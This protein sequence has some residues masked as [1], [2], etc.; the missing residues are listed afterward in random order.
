[1]QFE[2][3][4]AREALDTELAVGPSSPVTQRVVAFLRT[5]LAQNCLGAITWFE[6]CIDRHP[7]CSLF[8]AGAIDQDERIRSKARASTSHYLHLSLTAKWTPHHCILAI[9]DSKWTLPYEAF[10]E[11]HAKLCDM[12]SLLVYCEASAG[13]YLPDDAM[14]TLQ[15]AVRLICEYHVLDPGSFFQVVKALE[16]LGIGQLLSQVEEWSEPNDEFLRET[17]AGFL[18]H[19]HGYRFAQRWIALLRSQPVEFQTELSCLSKISGHPFVD[20]SGGVRKVQSR[21]RAPAEFAPGT[22][23]RLADLAK[24]QFCRAYYAKRR[25][26]PKISSLEGVPNHLKQMIEGNKR[27]D[28]AAIARIHGCALVA[29]DYR[30]LVLA[31]E[32]VVACYEN[33][34][35][36]LKDRTISPRL[37]EMVRVHIIPLLAKALAVPHGPR[38]SPA[39]K[40]RST[41]LLCH[42]I[43]S[44]MGQLGYDEFL[45]AYRRED[46]FELPLVK[47]ALLLKLVSKELELKSDDP[48]QFA[49]QTVPDRH[50]RQVTEAA[51]GTF[52]KE[53]SNE[54][55]MTS[56]EIKLQQQLSALRRWGKSHPDSTTLIVSLDVR[57]WNNGFR[58][59]LVDTVMSNTLA[60]YFGDPL[61]EAVH[62]AYE[63]TH[64][65]SIEGSSFVDYWFGQ[66]GGI[67]GLNQYTWVWV[68]LVM[69]HSIF[70]RWEYK[71][72]F[73]CHGDDFRAYISIPNSVVAARGMLA[74][75]QEIIAVVKRGLADFNLEVKTYDSYGSSTFSSFK[76]I[77]SVDSIV[78]PTAFRKMMKCHSSMDMVLPLLDAYIGTCFSTAHGGCFTAPTMVPAYAT[79]LMWACKH[80]LSHGLYA[81][82]PLSVLAA[83]LIVPANLGGFPTLCPENLA[84]RASADQTTDFINRYEF[85]RRCAPDLA[86]VFERFL[87]QPMGVVAAEG[88]SKAPVL[89][90]LDD[91]YAFP[92]SR[93]TLPLTLLRS[94]LV[95]HIR[96]IT[97]NELLR[98]IL[99]AAD[100][101]SDPAVADAL[102][103]SPVWSATLAAEIH[104]QSPQALL[105]DFLTKF[106]SG[107][108]VLQ[109]LL[110]AGTRKKVIAKTFR[111]CMRQE[112]KLHRWR[113]EVATGMKGLC[114]P[115]RRAVE[116]L[117]LDFRPRH[118]PHRRCP[119]RIRDTL[120]STA[121]GRKIETAVTA[122]P[123]HLV[124]IRTA[125]DVVASGPTAGHFLVDVQSTESHHA[126]RSQMY[127]RGPGEPYVAGATSSSTQPGSLIYPSEDPVARRLVNLV[128][129]KS[130]A[131]TPLPALDGNGDRTDSLSSLALYYLHALAPSSTVETLCQAGPSRLRGCR[132]HHIHTR[133]GRS[134]IAM[135]LSSSWFSKISVN[136]DANA[137][138]A[139]SAA[140]HNINYLHVVC[141]IRTTLLTRLL[142][143]YGSGPEDGTY[144]ASTD[145]CDH[146]HQPY[147]EHP[148]EFP[149]DRLLAR[150]SCMVQNLAV[151]HRELLRLEDAIKSYHLEHERVADDVDAQ[152]P[153][154]QQ[155]ACAIKCH[156]FTA[157]QN[158]HYAE[159]RD[160]FASTTG[161]LTHREVG[162]LA[163]LSLSGAPNLS[164]R[165]LR[166]IPISAFA[167]ELVVLAGTLYA[168]DGAPGLS[169]KDWFSYEA[170]AISPSLLPWYPVISYIHESG[171]VSD[172]VAQ[173][174][175][176]C[177]QPVPPTG[178]RTPVDTVR[179]VTLLGPALVEHP[180]RKATVLNVD[181]NVSEHGFMVR[182][183][184]WL[185]GRWAHHHARMW[186]VAFEEYDESCPAVRDYLVWKT[187][188]RHLHLPESLVAPALRDLRG[189]CR[190][191]T[192]R[193]FPLEQH[194]GPDP[195]LSDPESVGLLGTK[196]AL[197][198]LVQD[199]ESWCGDSD[200]ETLL[201]YVLTQIPRLGLQALDTVQCESLSGAEVTAV[202]EEMPIAYALDTE[203]PSREVTSSD[204]VR[205]SEAQLPECWRSLQPHKRLRYADL[206]AAEVRT[207][208]ITRSL[209]L[210]P[211][212]SL[213]H[214]SLLEAE[215]S[216]VF[217]G[218]G[219]APSS[220]PLSAVVIEDTGGAIT[221]WLLQR[222]P[223]M[224]VIVVLWR[225]SASLELPLTLRTRSD[226]AERV[227]T[228]LQA[229]GL[230]RIG[231]PGY[232]E[233]F[234]QTH[235]GPHAL[236]V[237]AQ[238]PG[239]NGED[240]HN[241][242]TSVLGLASQT[243]T[244]NCA[245]WVRFPDS[246]PSSLLGVVT[247]TSTVFRK[248]A[249]V[250]PECCPG[251]GHYG[252]VGHG[253][254]T[255]AIDQP[256]ILPTIAMRHLEEIDAA[257]VAR[258][259]L[260]RDH[261]H[262]A[263]ALPLTLPAESHGVC[264]PPEQALCSF[265]ANL[266]DAFGVTIAATN[267]HDAVQ[268][269]RA[270]IRGVRSGLS[271]SAHTLREAHRRTC[272]W[273]GLRLCMDLA[274]ELLP[275]DGLT[276]LPS[277]SV[278]RQCTY[279][280]RTL[281]LHG[282]RGWNSAVTWYDR[283]E[284]TAVLPG[285][286]YPAH[287]LERSPAWTQMRHSAVCCSYWLTWACKRP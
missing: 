283:P 26:W 141:H 57:A 126:L 188:F 285:E 173:L 39:D 56:S 148:M 14:P 79:A 259:Q 64:F 138:Y 41:S 263:D 255:T 5:P 278:C 194:H 60:A 243:G 9:K 62:A 75:K 175:A 244:S 221:R 102:S 47:S 124:Y 232:R 108:S 168:R 165:D 201:H 116:E 3:G 52:L 163:P 164:Q 258:D 215:A 107:R 63:H 80:L 103:Q 174:A 7:E 277:S 272:V 139:R 184:E 234:L 70:E 16:G 151:V 145:P 34:I 129:L 197:Q 214:P 45:Q 265:K 15:Q 43:T 172:F 147:V 67:E 95:P 109:L 61:F 83:L 2:D 76:K 254:P 146:C 97:R 54:H 206:G 185:L 104:S 30:N 127:E 46:R 135:N 192:L 120:A 49:A 200:S 140:R 170:S 96:S 130:W 89:Q 231:R 274:Q 225:Q 236:F 205:L 74:I 37:E 134:D 22:A 136:T 162:E 153:G 240:R 35:P 233:A 88:Y 183:R 253:L 261:A 238:V 213:Q 86:L 65:Y 13:V 66:G 203:G 250:C 167:T 166:K 152:D 6:S 281:E 122:P 73:L 100:Q 241:A 84:V 51:V 68:Y 266:L 217:T 150:P 186:S 242:L 132:L 31:Q 268:E 159:V 118:A 246:I 8:I 69:N 40:A 210:H 264:L 137:V 220:S 114:D 110:A 226:A 276:T 32:G 20:T 113:I 195:D 72:T 180:T 144:F 161:V 157:T 235:P 224:T 286:M 252:L 119:V 125:R 193:L 223:A 82:L 19:S 198:G 106:E 267:G 248:V 59:S 187:V 158:R 247:A 208:L 160:I 50:R 239:T 287:T 177:S 257:S 77:Q 270:A 112:Q 27:P 275:H 199:C 228:P 4:Y 53:F 229:T 17:L 212:V 92:I 178:C 251:S 58:A 33:P 105:T 237:V 25:R 182:L 133:A 280:R 211:E 29:E 98:E 28:D 111:R 18:P 123:R 176:F 143:G 36:L 71:Y 48:R 190:A 1:M 94:D 216:E 131:D 202:I 81:T 196:S 219:W 155:R 189:P 284:V 191:T 271:R 87:F 156:Q 204:W 222:Y 249:V 154:L 23:D 10:L 149:T 44:T 181:A 256:D 117:P 179:T 90:L 101:P 262:C 227:V 128:V 24:A 115:L 209:V 21:A 171:F 78:L 230:D 12:F 245:L 260:Y 282:S 121:W 38:V 279:I 85:A 218:M 99:Q 207:G 269:V 273:A 142:W 93:P 91:P 11:C 55:T 42:F 169:I